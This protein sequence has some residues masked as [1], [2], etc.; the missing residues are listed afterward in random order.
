MKKIVIITGVLTLTILVGYFFHHKTQRKLTLVEKSVFLQ[1]FATEIGQL[2]RNADL[3]GDQLCKK[4][5]NVDDSYYQCHPG[6]FKCLIDKDLIDFRMKKKKVSL[7]IS[8]SYKSIQRPTHIEYLFPLKVNGLYDLKLRLKDSCREVFLPQRYYPFL[9]NQRDVT[10]EWDNFNKKIFVDRN[11]SRV[12][13]VRQ[14]A[15]KVKNNIVLKK[16]KELPASD[17]AINL[18]IVEMQKYCSYQGKHILS[19][20]VFDAMSLH[21][22]DIS[23]PEVKL[24][25]AP[26][27]PWSR[28]NTKTNIFKIQ[29]K[30]DITLTEKQSENLCKRVYAKN[31]TSVPFQSYSSLSSTWMGARETLGGVMEYVTN[32]VHPKE[33]I[34]LSSKYYPWSSH[35]HRVGIRGYW[36]GEGRS[37]NNFDFGKYPIQVF[38]NSLDIGFRC[39]RFK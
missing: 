13:E 38:P 30:Q 16:L 37:M 14:W 1:A 9:A 23:S 3:E 7:K 8:S 34:V 12:W 35:V 39:M 11:L 15:T 21:P 25:R 5:L 18:E 29:K 31:C 27:F 19:A 36:D 26:Y 4:T 6:Y 32:T 33:N 17:I 20:K 28:K 22:E 24:F 2:W 10:I